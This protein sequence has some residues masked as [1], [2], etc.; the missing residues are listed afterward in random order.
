MLRAILKRLGILTAILLIFWSMIGCFGYARSD[1]LYYY[2]DITIAINDIKNN[3][4]GKHSVQNGLV[5][6]MK[7][8][9]GVFID[10]Y[11]DIELQADRKSVV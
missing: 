8:K 3:T 10:L 2:D 7:N 11:D 1:I 9:S 5:S 6:V 4:I